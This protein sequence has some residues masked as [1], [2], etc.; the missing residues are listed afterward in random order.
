MAHRVA[1]CVIS[2]GA[3]EKKKIYAKII[4]K[5]KAYQIRSALLMV[6]G[7]LVRQYIGAEVVPRRLFVTALQ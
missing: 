2:T 4:L 5:L 3:Q 6:Q 1:P 7:A